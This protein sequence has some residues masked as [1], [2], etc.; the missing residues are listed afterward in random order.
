MS[1]HG[2][3]IAGVSDIFHAIALLLQSVRGVLVA[4]TLAPVH[5]ASVIHLRMLLPHQRWSPPP[6]LRQTLR[7]GSA[8]G[9]TSQ[10]LTSGMGVLSGLVLPNL[11]VL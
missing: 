4:M 9:V 11:R 3:I 8:L 10:G 6:N 2:V 7:S 1:S 5:T